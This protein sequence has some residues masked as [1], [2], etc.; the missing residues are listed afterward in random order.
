MQTKKELPKSVQKYEDEN[1]KSFN[2][3]PVKL[4]NEGIENKLGTNIYC[5]S[6]I[7]FK[8]NIN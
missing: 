2:I 6:F 1:K 4:Y 3:D 8:Y 5:L 7:N